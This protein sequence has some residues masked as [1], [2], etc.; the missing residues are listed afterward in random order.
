MPL[1]KLVNRKLNLPISSIKLVGK[2]TFMSYLQLTLHCE[3]GNASIS[4]PCL[5]DPLHR[6]WQINTLLLRQSAY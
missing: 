5:F 1:G 4:C 3:K 2:E 6:D